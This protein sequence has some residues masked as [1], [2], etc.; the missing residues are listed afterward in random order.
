ME[1][2]LLERGGGTRT[3]AHEPGIG[4]P[5]GR[6]GEAPKAQ[7]PAGSGVEHVGR[8]REG[9]ASS[10]GGWDWRG[11]RGWRDDAGRVDRAA[12]DI[13]SYGRR[14]GENHRHPVLDK[15]G[16]LCAGRRKGMQG[17]ALG[18]ERVSALICH[19]GPLF[20]IRDR[21][22]RRCLLRAVGGNVKTNE[23]GRSAVEAT[24]EGT[25]Q[26]VI[27]RPRLGLGIPLQ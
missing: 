24:G 10:F 13:S 14:P 4:C 3:D 25:V 23:G 19:K 6:L 1:P 5:S 7:K 22:S 15:P 11:R 8:G 2:P 20:H 12:A 27:R 18:G 26:V 16:G 21:P 17:R 9:N